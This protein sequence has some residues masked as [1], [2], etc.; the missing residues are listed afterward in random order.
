MIT[1]DDDILSH[2][3]GLQNLENV[4]GNVGISCNVELVSSGGIGKQACGEGSLNINV[5]SVLLG[6]IDSLYWPK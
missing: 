2:A 4:D 1:L 5:N 6:I 3:D